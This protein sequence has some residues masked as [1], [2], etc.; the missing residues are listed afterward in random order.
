MNFYS[1]ASKLNK[2]IDRETLRQYRLKEHI[3]EN[4][5]INDINNNVRERKLKE[6]ETNCRLGIQLMLKYKE[7]AIEE[8][9]TKSDK[10]KQTFFI[11]IRPNSNEVNFITFH[12]DI[13]KF[14]DRKCF[15]NFT[16]TFE[17]K[18]ESE[19]ELG[20]GFHAHIIANMKQRSKTEVLRDT[21][22]TFKK[23]TNTNCIQVDIIKDEENYQRTIKYI[24][25]YESDDGHKASTKEW[26]A[27]WREKESLKEYYDTPPTIKSDVGS[28]QIRD[29]TEISWD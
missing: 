8:G 7:I 18:G 10:L 1:L 26:D 12:N 13:A 15:N 20:K 25:D 24:K 9:L 23:Y 4:I 22:S 11:T 14:V 21:I 16:L 28:V 3:E 19:N 5:N 6:F 2:D 29:I 27:L 17:Q